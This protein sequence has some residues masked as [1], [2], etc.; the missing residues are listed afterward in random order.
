M[1]EAANFGASGD[2]VTDDTAALEHALRDGDGV[3]H[4]HKGTFRLTRSLVF[5][6][7]QT[8]YAAV[9]GDGGASRLVKAGPGPGPGPGPE[10]GKR[11]PDVQ[12]KA[13]MK[14]CAAEP[15]IAS[16]LPDFARNAHGNL[17]EQNR[18]TGAQHGA[19]TT[20]PPP[21]SSLS[22]AARQDAVVA[23]STVVPPAVPKPSADSG[24]AAAIAL[25]Q[26]YTCVACHGMENKIV[27]PSFRDVAK[28]YAGRV[29]AV[30]YLTAK[31]RAGGS[32]VWGAIPMPPQALKDAEG[33]VIAQWLSDGASK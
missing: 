14:D 4:L 13:C 27:G 5:D 3:L 25:T 8:G 6:L 23:V 26:K 16:F 21:S 12:A 2:G 19:D 29:D 17:A 9:I 10:F 20:K 18:T 22:G 33:K 1:V 32:G 24:T 31:I 30:D 15:K 28:K 7:S 11:K